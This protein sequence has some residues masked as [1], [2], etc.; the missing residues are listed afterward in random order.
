MIW[1]TISQHITLGVRTIEGVGFPKF[2]A[3]LA[4][5]VALIARD[6]LG[7]CVCGILDRILMR[8]LLGSKPLLLLIRRSLNLVFSAFWAS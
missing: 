6:G 4:F 1:W 5:S 8:V 3:A 7:R 2:F